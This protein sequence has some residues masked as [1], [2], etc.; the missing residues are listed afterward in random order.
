IFNARRFDCRLDHV[1]T[2]MQVFEACM[3]LPAFQAAQ[4]EAC[5]DA[6]A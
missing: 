6:A 4:P 2:V 3:E 1:P 5:P